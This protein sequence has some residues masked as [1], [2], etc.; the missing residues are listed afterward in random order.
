M[1]AANAQLAASLARE[2]RFVGDAAHQLRTPLA[3]LRASV[4]LLATQPVQ[5]A[6]AVQQTLREVSRES[7]RLGRIVDDLLAL[8]RADAGMSIA[9]EPVDLL[10]LVDETYYLGRRLTG[11]DRLRLDL[12]HRPEDWDWVVLG[13]ERLLQQLLINLVD[14]A[15][16]YSPADEPVTIALGATRENVSISVTDYGAGIPAEEQER[17]FERF[18]R[19]PQ[20]RAGG[21][22]GSGLGLCLA[23]W[24]AEAH[25]GRLEVESV[26]GHGS[27]FRLCLRPP[28][29]AS[30]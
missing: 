11:G 29:S 21:A 14:N 20:A 28:P 7:D 3:I 19:T 12:G 26:V 15:L 30:T 17:I 9:R 24:I 18:Y 10:G 4:D 2:Q 27:T 22:T 16:K 8:T 25:G 13:D 5:S 1:E 6:A 23:R